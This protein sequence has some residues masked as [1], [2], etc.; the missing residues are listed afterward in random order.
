VADQDRLLRRGCGEVY[1]YWIVFM[2]GSE[3][4][5][6]GVRGDAGEVCGAADYGRPVR[7]SRADGTVGMSLKGDDY[8]S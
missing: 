3:L 2:S 6:V 5:A 8:G 4:G 1:G 7:C